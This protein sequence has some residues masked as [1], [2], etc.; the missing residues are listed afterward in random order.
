MLFIQAAGA[1]TDNLNK[2]NGNSGSYFDGA[3]YFP[4]GLVQFNGSSGA[5]T[6]CAMVVADLVDFTG[7]TNLQNSLTRPNG[8]PCTNNTTVTAYVVRLV[9]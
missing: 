7:N 2:I 1:T 3:M 5:M 4:S 6:Q 8:T 9:E